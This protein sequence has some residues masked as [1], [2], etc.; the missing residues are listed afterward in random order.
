M[1]LT[2]RERPDGVCIPAHARDAR[3]GVVGRF[4]RGDGRPGEGLLFAASHIHI[5][6][7]AAQFKGQTALAAGPLLLYWILQSGSVA[8]KETRGGE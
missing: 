8:R 1:L 4:R 7:S 3:V 2:G 6:D 5:Q